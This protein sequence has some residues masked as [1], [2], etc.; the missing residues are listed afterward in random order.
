MISTTGS[1]EFH[2]ARTGFMDAQ[3]AAF[4]A[5]ANIAVQGLQKIVALNIAAAKAAADDAAVIAK[6]FIA[7]K[8][9]QTFFA[10]AS[11]YAKPNAEKLSAYSH[12]LTDILTSVKDEFAKAADTQGADVQRKAGE[13]A[14]SAAQQ[15]AAG[16]DHAD[17]ALQATAANAQEGH[18][19]AGAAVRQAA[20]ATAAQYDKTADKLAEIAKKTTVR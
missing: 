7:A 16:V 10:V 15:V 19:K 12:Q 6:D 4:S 9:P 20:D 14:N 2:A 17:A 18:D 3:L 11:A 8:D 13:L 1:T 5:L